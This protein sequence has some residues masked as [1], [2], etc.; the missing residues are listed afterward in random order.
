[1]SQDAWNNAKGISSIRSPCPKKTSKTC[2]NIG[3][4]YRRPETANSDHSLDVFSGQSD[5]IKLI[6]FEFFQASW[7]TS[8]EYPQHIILKTFKFHFSGIDPPLGDP[9]KY[10]SAKTK[11]FPVFLSILVTTLDTCCTNLNTYW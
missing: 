6:P 10:F 8:L 9:Q 7:D 2:I 4:F 5:R 3:I 11:H 1:V